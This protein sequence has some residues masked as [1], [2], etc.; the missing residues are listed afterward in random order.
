MT[1]A[2]SGSGSTV[3]AVSV[4]THADQSYCLMSKG[5]IFVILK[6]DFLLAVLKHTSYIV[7]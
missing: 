5:T 7:I 6:I 3:T 1:G 4:N 2:Y